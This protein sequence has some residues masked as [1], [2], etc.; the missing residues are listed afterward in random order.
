MS[1]SLP[2]YAQKEVSTSAG[3]KVGAIISRTM[4][5]ITAPVST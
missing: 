4:L 1:A 2:G 3:S 5:I